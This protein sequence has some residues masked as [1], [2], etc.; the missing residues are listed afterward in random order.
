MRSCPRIVPRGLVVTLRLGIKAGE[1]PVRVGRQLEIALDDKRRVRVVD[2][3]I[4]RDAVVLDGVA[5]DAAEKSD[6]RTGANLAEEI[7]DRGGAREARIDGDYLGIACTLR[8]TRPL[9]IAPRPHV[10][11]KLETVGPCQTL[12]WFSKCTTPRARMDFTTR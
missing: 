11:P 7:G 1:H 8:F 12:A 9:V 6:V 4:F 3:V 10:G 5:N 2:Q